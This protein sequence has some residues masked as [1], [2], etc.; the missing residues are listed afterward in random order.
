[1]ATFAANS[2]A[3]WDTGAACVPNQLVE[4]Y[5]AEAVGIIA[6]IAAKQR[7][8]RFK[9]FGELLENL[10]PQCSSLAD[11]LIRFQ[12]DKLLL[13][14]D[15]RHDEHLSLF[16]FG[17]TSHAGRVMR[18]F[19]FLE[20]PY[21]DTALH[22][23]QVHQYLDI[24]G[25]RPVRV[26]EALCDYDFRYLSLCGRPSDYRKFKEI[27]ATEFYAFATARESAEDWEWDEAVAFYRAATAERRCGHE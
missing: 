9:D 18:I 11:W 21:T 12:Q 22:R 24:D 8:S 3:Y 26:E 15:I 1:V 19:W 4:H 5:P 14:A 25:A 2:T 17:D 6:K 23:C 10:Q 20:E 13:L 7:D 27:M 16:N